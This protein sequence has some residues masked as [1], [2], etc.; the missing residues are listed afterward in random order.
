[1]KNTLFVMNVKVNFLNQV[2]WWKLYARS[3]QVLY[4]VIRIVTIFLKMADAYIAIGMEAE[5]II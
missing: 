1:M 5:A 2:Q 4:M 3:A